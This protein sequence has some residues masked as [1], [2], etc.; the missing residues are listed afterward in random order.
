MEGIRGWTKIILAIWRWKFPSTVGAYC[1]SPLHIWIINRFA[2]AYFLASSVSPQRHSDEGR[3]SELY[4]NPI[5]KSIRIALVYRSW[6]FASPYSSFWR[7]KNLGTIP[8]SNFE[9]NKDCISVQVLHLRCRMTARFLTLPYRF[10]THRSEL[11]VPWEGFRVKRRIYFCF[12]LWGLGHS[13]IVRWGNH[14][15]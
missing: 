4:K 6:A 11:E 5:L 12:F 3:I 2:L 1:I 13:E 15:I 10:F 7:R 8:K 9:I 14:F